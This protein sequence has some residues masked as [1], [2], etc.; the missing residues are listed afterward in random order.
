MTD[1]AKIT[2]SIKL[3]AKILN[4]DKSEQKNFFSK[5]RDEFY[6]VLGNKFRPILED[7]SMPAKEKIFDEILKI[8]DEQEIFGSLP[9]LI[10][11]TFVGIFGFDKNLVRR[12]I[13]SIANVETAKSLILDTN[14]PTILIAGDKNITAINDV[15]NHIDLNF[16]EYAKT[17]FLWRDNIEIPQILRFFFMRQKLMFQN[18]AIVYLPEH[19]NSET[20]IGR[21]IL[22]RLDAG[23]V[24]VS[25]PSDKIK[26]RKLLEEVFKLQNNNQNSFY[27]VT[28]SENDERFKKLIITPENGVVPILEQL[29]VL[30]CNYLFS[31]A[32]KNKLLAIRK[33]Y[34]EKIRLLKADKS[35]I[36]G[37]LALITM[38]ET[39]ETVRE[40][41]RE[42]RRELNEVESEFEKLRGVSALLTDAT[43]KYKIVFENF[44]GVKENIRYRESTKEIWREIFFKAIDIS[45]FKLAAE[46]MRNLERAGDSYNYIYKMIINSATGESVSWESVDRLRHEPDNEFVRRAKIRL[47][48]KLHFSEFDY[49]QIARDINLIETP[50]E[51]YFRGLWENHAGNKEMAIYYLNCALKQNYEP[52]GKFLFSLS[53][54]D[55]TKLQILSDKMVA[56]AN[57]ELGKMNLADDRYAAANKYFKLAAIKGHIPAIKILADD[58]SKKLFKNSG[59]NRILSDSDKNQAIRCIEIYKEI[60]NKSG[61]ISVKETIGDIYHILN[62]DRR[63]SDWWQQCETATAYYKRGRLYQY[64]DGVFSQDLNEAEKLFKKAVSM[65]HRKA[66][67]EL[68]KVQQWKNEKN[69]HAQ[70]A[71]KINHAPRVYTSSSSSSSSGGGLCVITSAACA[72]LHKSDDCEELNIL[73]AYRD[74]MKNEN[75]VIATLIE[76]YY[77]VAPLLVNKMDLESEAEKI[78][79]ELWK[80]Y[81]S[82]TYRLI[83]AEKNNEATL[84]YIEMVQKLCEHYGVE[85]SEGINEKIQSYSTK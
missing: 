75:P 79:S 3:S 9:E 70:Q 19:F 14:L 4:A 37:D 8:A 43:N 72:A 18:I 32:I 85:L 48:D 33:F 68:K 41:E 44:L 64:Q 26:N 34:E 46:Y 5:S 67:E 56:E 30:R 78:Y 63:A 53:Q 80:K 42:I 38:N 6:N 11:K 35:Q 66:D 22:Q 24:Y 50:A 77:R 47:A 27:I 52:A 36:A 1:E 16:S 23:I 71:K 25:S 29:N 13:E 2:E 45:D 39:K 58:F 65:G 20:A 60:L 81:I 69:R 61:D 10:G 55:K 82:E 15:G 40:L 31:D 76:E 83:K 57:F 74:K 12:L 49:M 73:R 59:A 17:N 28:D 7:S 54:N 62:D 21:K 84:I 51:N